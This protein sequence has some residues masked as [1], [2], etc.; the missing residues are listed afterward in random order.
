MTCDHVYHRGCAERWFVRH[1]VCPAVG[2]DCHCD[3]LDDDDVED[4]EV[5]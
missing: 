2:C 4:D 5:G 1:G 3:E